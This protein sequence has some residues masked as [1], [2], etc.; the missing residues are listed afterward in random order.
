AGAGLHE[1]VVALSERALDGGGHLELL[2]AVLV[3]LA[4]AAG[5]RAF[6]AEDGG[7]GGGQR[8]LI[9]TEPPRD[10]I[11]DPRSPAGWTTR[12]TLNRQSTSARIRPV[13]EAARSPSCREVS[14]EGVGGASSAKWH[15]DRS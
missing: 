12:G 11:G 15:S 14:R 7:E 9:L 5:D 6:G 3:A 1:Q 2:G 4:E 13:P 8:G 10:A